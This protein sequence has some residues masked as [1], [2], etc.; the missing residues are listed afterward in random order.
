ML[1]QVSRSIGDAY[2]KHAQFNREPINPKFRISE[3]MRMPILSANPS[4]VSHHLQP[5]DCFLIFAS[6]GLWEHLSNQEAVDIVHNH[7]RTVRLGRYC[8]LLQLLI[9]IFLNYIISFASFLSIVLHLILGLLHACLCKIISFDFSFSIYPL[10]CSVS[11]KIPLS[12]RFIQSMGGYTGFVLETSFYSGAFIVST[13]L[14][15]WKLGFWRAC[16]ENQPFTGYV[17][18]ISNFA[19]VICKSI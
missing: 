14:Y 13:T 3:P 11:Y 18:K 19:G 4:I 2:M 15:V 12:W 7:P 10:K 1:L 5:S 9:L 8:C 16:I 17:C 6:D